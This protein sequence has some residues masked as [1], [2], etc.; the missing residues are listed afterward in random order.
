VATTKLERVY[1]Y[2]SAKP[3]KEPDR[4]KRAEKKPGELPVGVIVGSVEIT[5][6]KKRGER[7]FAYVLRN[8]KRLR[9]HIKPKNHAS[10][11]FWKPRI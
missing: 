11:V 5:G 4:W 7:D 10:P 1:I 6:C 2:A 3:R 8:P 9:I